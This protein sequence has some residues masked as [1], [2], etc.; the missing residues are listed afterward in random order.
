MNQFV[1]RLGVFAEDMAL[2]GEMEL[3]SKIF[4][5]DVIAKV[6]IQAVR[7]FANHG[8]GCR[9]LLEELHHLSELLAACG[10]CR[11]NIYEL[12]ENFDAVFER[13][14]A[15]QFQLCGDG[16]TFFLLVFT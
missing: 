6:A 7:F 10:L 14:F 16:E 5:G 11:L 15:K 4:N 12:A 9:V 2:F 1:L 8:T 13:V 3:D